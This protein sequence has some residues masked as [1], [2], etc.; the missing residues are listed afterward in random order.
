MMSFYKASVYYM[1]IVVALGLNFHSQGQDVKYDPKGNPEKWN[2][3]I[4]PFFVLPWIDG[5]ISS[6]RLSKEFGID[7]SEFI[8]TLNFTF[9]M[10]AEVSKGKFFA[11]PTYLYNYN[12][13][14]QVLWTSENEELSITFNPKYQRHIFELIAGMRFRLGNKFMLDP[15]AGFRYTHYRLFGSIDGIANTNELDEKTDF[16]DPVI[17][18]KAHYYPHPRVP[19]ELKA[20]IGGFG[21]GSKLTWSTWLNSG[22]TVSPVVDLIAGFGALS[23]EYENETGSG[24]TFGM[25]SL[26]YGVTMGARFYIPSRGKDPAIFKKYIKE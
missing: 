26:T 15:Y 1:F 23:N 9:M 21:V 17:G 18:F 5:E 20:D 8:S 6:E 13:V 14:E 4:T 7:P 22:Y 12:E 11:A 10:T 25:T 16:W 2:F 3:Q 19:V 24:R